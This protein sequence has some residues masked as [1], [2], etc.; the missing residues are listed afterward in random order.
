VSFGVASTA[1]GASTL[2]ELLE[3]S[4]RALYASKEAGRDRVT[5]WEDIAD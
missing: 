3:Q 4:D 1:S 2:A 5:R